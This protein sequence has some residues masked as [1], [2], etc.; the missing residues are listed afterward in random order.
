MNILKYKK[1]FT[2]TIQS[3]TFQYSIISIFLV[4]Q[5]VVFTSNIYSASQ[6]K[7]LLFVN[8]ELVNENLSYEETDVNKTEEKTESLYSKDSV[9]STD[10]SDMKTSSEEN[11]EKKKSNLEVELK[12]KKDIGENQLPERTKNQSNSITEEKELKDIIRTSKAVKRLRV[13]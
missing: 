2:K 8:E 11:V 12:E 3:S 10:E 6:N 1:Y 13:W 4:L 7:P 9:E 5:L